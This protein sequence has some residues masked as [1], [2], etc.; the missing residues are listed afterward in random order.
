MNTF[1]NFQEAI[2]KELENYIHY[3]N[4]FLKFNFNNVV[5]IETPQ[6][7]NERVADFS[8]KM[9]QFSKAINLIFEKVTK[10]F[11]AKK[12]NEG[13]YKIIYVYADSSD[14]D[15]QRYI[16]L[17]EEGCDIINDNLNN[18]PVNL[19]EEYTKKFI[20]ELSR[21][22][23]QIRGTKH[24]INNA[25]LSR[26]FLLGDVGVGK[27]AF[28]N[29]VF[30]RYHSELKKDKV[31]WV[32]V[33]LTK[34]HLRDRTLMDALNFQ[35]SKVFRAHYFD[36]LTDDEESELR[37]LL[38]DCFKEARN[39]PFLEAF[40]RCYNEFTAPYDKARMENYDNRIETG[41][42]RYMERN[43]GVIYIFDGLDKIDA[44][45]LFKKKMNEV[46]DI[47][48]NEKCK[49]V[50]LFVMRNKS[51]KDY[52]DT[53]LPA[54]YSAQTNLRGTN[55]VFKIIPPKLDD[56]ID[57]RIS[58][59]LEKA[60]EYFE[61]CKLSIYPSG[62]FLSQLTPGEEKDVEDIKRKIQNMTK[63]EYEAYLNVFLMYLYKGITKREVV[64]SEWDR[65]KS[66]TELKNLVGDNFRKLLAIIQSANKVFLVTIGTLNYEFEDIIS[67]HNAIDNPAMEG[68]SN[69]KDKLDNILR[70]SYKI[71][72]VLLKNR[73]GRFENPYA[74]EYSVD[75]K[76]QQK[77]KNFDPDKIPYIY[78]LY[79]S[80]NV[81][82]VKE[83]KFY[84]LLK[85]RILQYINK[86]GEIKNEQEISS[87][88]SKDFY[89]SED[90]ILLAFKELFDW[91]LITTELKETYEARTT[92]LNYIYKLSRA[93][94]YHLEILIKEFSYIMLIMD[95]IL[96][97]KELC[98]RFI[99]NHYA[100]GVSKKVEHYIRQ[101][102]RIVN[103]ISMIYAIEL[104]EKVDIIKDEWAIFPC[105][106]K[107]VIETFAK[108]LSR[109]DSDL[110]LL[111][112]VL[113]YK[114]I[115]Q[116]AD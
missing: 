103:F 100:Q 105:I 32:R 13:I 95:D 6:E 30:S 72:D 89:Y 26:F 66:F 71:I 36:D 64:L 96:V 9:N 69:H 52:L 38:S 2:K 37:S 35:I 76:I 116:S 47:L 80:V 44:N 77:N 19:D 27:T 23:I 55:K 109:Y 58:L 12:E 65:R 41:I 17:K 46:R 28:L 102:P 106:Y 61:Y 85:I 34:S 79:Y 5:L 39:G 114:G 115:S 45:Q 50:F 68:F 29:N 15:Y 67:I 91:G 31:C 20:V 8:S 107:A 25:Q 98:E 54:E 40:E 81:P 43:Y 51:H 22:A 94:K 1:D 7:D 10:T 108:I 3:Q 18:I 60:D 113:E 62:K 14:P 88:F 4:P 70:K 53:L 111:K 93:G 99:E 73:N 90:S 75:G 104:E 57:K 86:N 24:N 78:N 63:E 56:I 48:S 82:N 33:D 74:Y 101:F 16:H 11:E 112:N 49:G 59:I 42:K 97:P 84:F 83:P 21:R 110:N 92:T 87:F